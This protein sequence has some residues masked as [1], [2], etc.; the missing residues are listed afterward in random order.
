MSLP[1]VETSFQLAESPGRRRKGRTSTPKRREVKKE[2][3]PS[4]EIIVHEE[5]EEDIDEEI[6]SSEGDD[7]TSVQK[8]VEKL[9]QGLGLIPSPSTPKSSRKRKLT[10][11][12]SDSSSEEE[13]W[14]D[15]IK[16]G[17]LEEV[18]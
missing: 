8:Y 7:S 11:K 4:P 1:G 3:I 6:D 12:D 2:R 15:A 13:R 10:K 14:L 17:K 16:S 18:S 9:S 5:E